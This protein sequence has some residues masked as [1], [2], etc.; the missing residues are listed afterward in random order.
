MFV[1]VLMFL[2]LSLND[3]TVKHDCCKF[4][5]LN[6]RVLSGSAP[7]LPHTTNG[8]GTHHD[9]PVVKNRAL[10]KQKYY[11]DKLYPE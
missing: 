7:V 11:G 8:C 2:L 6:L 5:S 10:V 4:A 9:P 1:C 3:S